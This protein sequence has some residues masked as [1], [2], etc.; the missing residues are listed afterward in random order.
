MRVSRRS[1]TAVVCGALASVAAAGQEQVPEAS[2]SAGPPAASSSPAA[3][4]LGSPAVD[5]PGGLASAAKTP[6]HALE[7][8]GYAILGG[9]WTQADP[10]LLS[11]GRTNGFAL[12]DARLEVTGRPT[13]NLWLYLSIDG[14]APVYGS[15]PLQGSRA[16]LLRDA[17]GVW[18]PGGHL[19]VQAGQFKAP[20]D[21]EE[22]LEETELKFATRSIVSDGQMPP[23]GYT[24]QGLG[25]GRQL[26][27]ALGTDRVPFGFGSIIAQLAVMN[28]NGANQLYN[29][30]QFPSAVGRVSFELPLHLQ[31]GVDGYFQP[32]ASGTQP[33]V[34]RDNLAG[35][36]GDLRFERAG[37]HALL[38]AQLRN[39][40]HLTSGAPDEVAL[41]L[42]A[43]GAFRIGSLEP[44]VRLSYLSPS[45]QIPVAA[46]NQLTAG[47][48]LYAPDA[49]ARLSID[50]THRGERAER[51]LQNDGLEVA[52]QVRF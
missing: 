8:S 17:Y 50:Y 19:R 39:T 28:G 29:D 44:A 5:A 24:A 20:Q 9:S 22:L 45:N 32:R 10:Q 18:A 30:S 47:V 33:T 12:G 51:S 42:S 2:R 3:V 36:G 46:I 27:L 31:L 15:D 34:Y 16:V 1:L 41:G 48:N 11:V 14:A 21:V 4:G 40:H 37:F 52:A 49:P 13:E 25:L 35:V 38:L 6:A 43:E 7:I 23:D 26:G